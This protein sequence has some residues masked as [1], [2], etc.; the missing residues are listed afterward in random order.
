MNR[1]NRSGGVKFREL[2]YSKS[3][4]SKEPTNK[5]PLRSKADVLKLFAEASDVREK[6]NRSDDNN[7]C[8]VENTS[9]DVTTVDDVNF[10]D[11]FEDENKTERDVEVKDEETFVKQEAKPKI[12]IAIREK[13][14]IQSNVVGTSMARKENTD[15]RGQQKCSQPS[16]SAPVADGKR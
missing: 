8:T 16:Q 7:I 5:I 2:D 10:E 12:D 15:S 6:E 13:P 14:K 1:N 3:S 11:P 9:D 4:P